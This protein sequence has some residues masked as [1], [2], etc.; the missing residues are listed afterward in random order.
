MILERIYNLVQQGLDFASALESV[1]VNGF[2][3]HTAV[4]AG[5]DHFSPDMMQSYFDSFYRSLNISYDDFMAL[6]HVP[7]SAD[8]NMTALAIHGSR[9]HNGVSKIH[10]GVSAD[11][12]RDLWPQIEPEENPITY[13]TNGV[14]VPTFLAQSGRICLTVIWAMNGAIKCAIPST[15]RGLMQFPIICSGACGSR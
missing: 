14:H 7:G 2:T 8:F 6:G 11:I 3:T 13:V 9:T 4:P 12:C 10:G 5:H 15:G 1:A